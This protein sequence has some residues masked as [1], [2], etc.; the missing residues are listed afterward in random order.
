MVN[1]DIIIKGQRSL[2]LVEYPP[3]PKVS[4]RKVVYRNLNLH[5]QV[6]VLFPLFTLIIYLIYLYS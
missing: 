1:K 2:P 3:G 6:P 5:L 4:P